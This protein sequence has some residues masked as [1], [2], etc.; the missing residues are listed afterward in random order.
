MGEWCKVQEFVLEHTSLVRFRNFNGTNYILDTAPIFSDGDGEPFI[1]TRSFI[2]ESEL[3]ELVEQ[4]RSPDAGTGCFEV[5]DVWYGHI[6]DM[7]ATAEFE[8]RR[9]FTRGV[10]LRRIGNVR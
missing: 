3:T 4:V 10:Y 9:C 8:A 1:A 6:V 5:D 7:G 2:E